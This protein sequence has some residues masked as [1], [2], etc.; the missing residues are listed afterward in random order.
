[1]SY[2]PTTIAFVDT[3]TTG[4]DPEVD[5]I[6][7][8]AVIVWD[9][10]TAQW[11]EHTW[12]QE[13]PLVYVMPG[14]N[15]DDP[16]IVGNASPTAW[17]SDW[18]KANTRLLA[19]YDHDAALTE[20]R[21]EWMLRELLTGKHIVGAVP[22]F[23]ADRLHRLIRRVDPE[24][25]ATSTPWHYHLIDVETLMVGFGRGV[26]TSGGKGWIGK[27]PWENLPWSSTDL[28]RWCE[29]E[30]DLFGPAHDA[31]NDARWARAC[32]EAVMGSPLPVRTSTE[33]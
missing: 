21:T 30:P 9:S 22:S 24:R 23:D 8:I 4:L 19:D 33:F 12:Q 27:Q 15:T 10:A 25:W 29:V 20:D 28:S 2:D 14:T 16:N 5:R 18:V 7:Q 32:Y 11:S 6:W 31:L 3:E 17:A 26:S 13:L 1:M